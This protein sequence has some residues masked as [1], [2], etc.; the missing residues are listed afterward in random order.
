VR[1]DAASF[2]EKIQDLAPHNDYE[3]LLQ[4]QACRLPTPR[5]NAFPVAAAGG[6]LRPGTVF[7]GDG[8]LANRHLHR[9]RSVRTQEP[10][11][12]RYP[13]RVRA[14]SVSGAIYLILELDGPSPG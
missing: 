12:D 6:Q 2:Y 11:R 14:L 5:A 7:G 3:R 8:L 9:L 13:D 4:S 1:S 10:S